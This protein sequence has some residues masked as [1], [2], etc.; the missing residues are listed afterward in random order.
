MLKAQG[1]KTVI[2]MFIK[3]HA[4]N[5]IRHNVK[6][7]A[8]DIVK[9]ILASICAVLFAGEIRKICETCRAISLCVA[10]RRCYRLIIRIEYVSCE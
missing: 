6:N 1:Q 5:N 7:K 3:V 9:E 10:A 8:L 4:D 2:R